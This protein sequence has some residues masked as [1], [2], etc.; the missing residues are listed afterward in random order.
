MPNEPN[1]NRYLDT[2]SGQMHMQVHM[3]P[4]QIT[5][6][7]KSDKLKMFVNQK[8][9]LAGKGLSKMRAFSSNLHKMHAFS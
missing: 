8:I 4:G 5:L 3:K 6:N 9:T 2:K 7:L 1:I